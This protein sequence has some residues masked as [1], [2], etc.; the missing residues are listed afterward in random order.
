MKNQCFASKSANLPVGVEEADV[1]LLIGTNPR[2]EAPLF[3]S[4]IRKSYL[5]NET[6]V[7]LIGPAVDLTYEYEHVGE[8]LSVLSEL[9]EGRGKFWNRLCKA[10]KPL[11][12]LGADQLDRPDGAAILAAVQQLSRKLSTNI[13]V[14]FF[15]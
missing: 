7:A 8:D 5:H 10:K 6:D 14:S 13:E 9:A 4:R 11:I 1:V 2:Y 15:V 3:N 12:V